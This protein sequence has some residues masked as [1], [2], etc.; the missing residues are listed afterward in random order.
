MLFSTYMGDAREDGARDAA[1][2]GNHVFLTGAE[3]GPST[4]PSLS[5]GP[6]FV[7]QLT[8]AG[9]LVYR[10]RLLAIPDAIAADANG[11]AYV[12]G[13]TT[14]YGLATPGA[15]QTTGAY[16]DCGSRFQSVLCGDGFVTKLSPGGESL[17]YSTYL[18][19][20]VFQGRGATDRV[21][22]IAV[23]AAGHAYVTG[24]TSSNSF[25]TT[26]GAYQTA[27]RQVG[28]NTFVTKFNPTG[29]DLMFSTFLGPSIGGL[30]I[31]LGANGTVHVGGFT[32][33]L[34]FPTVEAH[35]PQSGS[36]PLYKSVDG[37]VGWEAIGRGL[38]PRLF[39]SVSEIVSAASDP[40]RL[41]ASSDDG[42]GYRSNDGGGSWSSL[43]VNLVWGIRALAVDPADA[44]VVYLLDWEACYTGRPTEGRRRSSS[45]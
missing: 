20:G 31:A 17:G 23:D 2:A 25:P 42:Y 21:Y 24:Y 34:D 8:S 7:A 33:S 29:T 43:D 38:E 13:W 1:A 5:T 11:A 37:G 12:A 14:A 26:P 3:G 32:F 36:G 27:A 22:D 15:F 40:L 39:T 41:Y 44:S 18:R 45:P 19:E 16:S 9:A 4:N 28:E 6:G 30:A 35:Q 10:S